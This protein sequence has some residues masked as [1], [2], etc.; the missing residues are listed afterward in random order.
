MCTPDALT[1]LHIFPISPSCM[2]SV[3]VVS[4]PWSWIAVSF[5]AGV[6]G[7]LAVNF[8]ALSSVGLQLA[9]VVF[10]HCQE[11][12][13]FVLMACLSPTAIFLC[14]LY[15]LLTP[16]IEIAFS[17]PQ[18]KKYLQVI[19]SCTYLFSS[20]SLKFSFSCGLSSLCDK[21]LTSFPLHGSLCCP[22]SW[23]VWV[24]QR[25]AAIWS[26]LIRQRMM[27]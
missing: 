14:V 4:F 25:A 24:D 26:C 18:L 21:L 16:R 27:L 7:M 22:A 15:L 9:I 11:C 8:H 3:F 6:P 19:L 10:R 17:S 1:C 20:I 23:R 5:H 12:S 13:T 2:T